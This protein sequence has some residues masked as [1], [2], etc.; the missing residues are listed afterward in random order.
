MSLTKGRNQ[1]SREIERHLASWVGTLSMCC[2][3]AFAPGCGSSEAQKSA[4][5]LDTE[6][7]ENRPG[8]TA[9]GQ[10]IDSPVAGLFYRTET[11]EGFTD[12]NG[13]FEYRQGETVS[14]HIGNIDLGSTDVSA[15]VTPED[16]AEESSG[17]LSDTAVNIL[18]LLQT[19]DEDGDPSNGIAIS[20]STHV[21]AS[22]IQE[23]SISVTVSCSEFESNATLME[24]IGQTTNVANL[25]DE[26]GA[27]EHYQTTLVML[28][29]R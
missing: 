11:L 14:F 19:L 24:L 15:V 22:Q 3:M 4:P 13:Y 10:F 28:Q 17:T 29:T 21:A 25:V 8:L 7:V 16:L 27:I 2:A 9:R 12:H 18:R 5:E 23:N 26:N 20:D 6:G 1:G